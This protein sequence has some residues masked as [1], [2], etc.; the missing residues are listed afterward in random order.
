ME[1]IMQKQIYLTAAQVRER[2][3]RVSRMWIH[4]R[5]DDSGFP[6]PV[7]FARLRYWR[8]NDLEQWDVEMAAKSGPASLHRP[9]ARRAV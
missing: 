3:G 6:A 4:R 5:T 9:H 2:Y 1:R 7:R 8:A